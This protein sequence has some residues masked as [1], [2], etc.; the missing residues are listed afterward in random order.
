M[1]TTITSLTF[2]GGANTSTGI[3]SDT[4]PTVLVGI[5]ATSGNNNDIG[6]F[7]LPNGVWTGLG[8]GGS[9]AGV[10]YWQSAIGANINNIMYIFAI[11]DSNRLWTTYYLG[12][13]A[14]QTWFNTWFLNA[15]PFVPARLLATAGDYL[16]VLDTQN[17]P[18]I[19]G[20]VAVGA[21]YNNNNAQW[22]QTLALNEGLYVEPQILQI[23]AGAI[24]ENQLTPDDDC[25][26]NFNIVN[27]SSDY[28]LSNIQLT[29]SFPAP[30]AGGTSPVVATGGT[31]ATLV[32]GLGEPDDTGTYPP[33]VVPV[34]LSPGASYAVT[35]Q[36]YA[37][38]AC[39]PGAYPFNVALTAYQMQLATSGGIPICVDLGQQITVVAN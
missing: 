21:A 26:Y 14:W 32:C 28:I 33:Y 25:N 13:G 7:W 36:V 37:T 18:W 19:I 30:A 5:M 16:V 29:F 17:N 31:P 38:S 20:Y 22:A 1:A 12:S 23:S 34:S 4:W 24:D 35:F 11:D 15:P 6:Q 39:Q 9:P 27:T 8:N 3:P 2:C 10:N